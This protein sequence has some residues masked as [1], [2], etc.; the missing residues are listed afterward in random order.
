MTTYGSLERGCTAKPACSNNGTA[1]AST[2]SSF[3][4]VVV[5][6]ASTTPPPRRLIAASAPSS[7]ARAT[8]RWRCRTAV[9]KHVMR[10]STSGA[11]G[12]MRR[13]RRVLPGSGSSSTGPNWH[14]RIDAPR[15]TFEFDQLLDGVVT[16]SRKDTGIQPGGA[17]GLRRVSALSFRAVSADAGITSRWPVGRAQ[18]PRRDVGWDASAATRR[19]L[20]TGLARPCGG[21]PSFRRRSG[22]LSS[23]TS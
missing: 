10:Q 14:H 9:T 13:S 15:R 1:P 17:V 3:S 23:P 12:W 4:G 21:H 5:E 6:Y 11:S 7:A 19:A 18:H 22:G 20:G 8:P 16:E 2:Q